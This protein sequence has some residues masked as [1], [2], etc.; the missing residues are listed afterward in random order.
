MPKHNTNQYRR[1]MVNF[2]PIT[3]TTELRTKTDYHTQNANELD[4]NII[5]TFTTTLD[6]LAPIRKL[7]K[8]EIKNN[9]KPWLTKG[10]LNSIKIKNKWLKKFINSKN[11][12]HYK[13]YKTYRDKLNSLIRISKR[14]YYKTYFT[15]HLQNTKKTWTG[16]NELL[17][18]KR[19]ALQNT[20]S[21]CI[22]I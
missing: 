8:K 11:N 21:L 20:I 12:L 22:T 13:T 1:K 4:K 2:N 10:I 15:E 6:Q 9:I 14:N 3:F 18:N 19:N 7:S 16:I 5:D 17:G